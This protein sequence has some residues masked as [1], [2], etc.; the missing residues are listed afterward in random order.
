MFQVQDKLSFFESIIALKLINEDCIFSLNMLN[1]RFSSA[2]AMNVCLT[3][4]D[5]KSRNMQLM[6]LLKCFTDS[7]EQ[8]EIFDL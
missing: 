7:S 5:V 2:F 8:C 6:F 1:K 4:W 3:L